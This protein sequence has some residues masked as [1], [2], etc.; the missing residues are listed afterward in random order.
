MTLRHLRIFVTV[1]DQGSATA[2]ANVL[3][4]AQPAVSLAIRELEEYYGIKL[5]DRIG[6]RLH[7]T[8][9]GKI[10]YSYAAHIITT[11][12]EMENGLRNWD[13]IGRLRIGSSIT[14]GNKMLPELIHDFSLVYPKIDVKVLIESSDVIEEKLLRSELDFALIEG[15]THSM[16]LITHSFADDELAV[17]CSSLHPFAS[18]K[19]ITG[20][21]FVKERILLRERGSGTRELFDS[22]MEIHGYACIPAW[23]STSTRA[24]L[25]AVVENLG[26]A[27]VPKRLIEIER[28]SQLIECIHIENIEFKRNFNIVYHKNK[29]L[30]KSIKEFMKLCDDVEK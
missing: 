1:V 21:D 13:E 12:E 16:D 8:E 2:A 29:Y 5:F 26:I 7:L 20:D 3:Y 6:N 17:V 14:I 28:T 27:V 25:S 22:V 15:V 24:L 19:V 18:K 23:E 4:L 11:F 9:A 30:S 10:F